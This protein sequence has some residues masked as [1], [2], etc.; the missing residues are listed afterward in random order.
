MAR[1]YIGTSGWVYGAWKGRFYPH[2]LPDAQRLSFYATK[3]A[4][5]EINYSYYHLPFLQ[6]Y[7]KWAM[8]VPPGF[9]FA[10]KA[11][12][13]ITHL[14]RL[15]NVDKAWKDFVQGAKELRQHLGPILV[16]LPPSF[17]KNHDRLKAFLE[18]TS[19]TDTSLRLAFEFRHESWFAEETYKLL[20]RYGAALCIADSISRPRLNRVTADFAYVR[21]HGRTPRE[22]PCYT[23][24]ELRQEA[25]FIGRL[26]GQGIDAYVYFNN[27]ALAHAPSN[28]ARLEELLN[29]MRRAA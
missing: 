26:V 24:E 18:T 15:K 4:A 25:K 8:L 13:A 22:A 12:R 23:D 27:D 11:N 10:I 29:E 19:G 14:A 5:T 17:R 16:Q 1:V 7:R 28:A 20:T 6:T 9:V 21:Y 3:F 2:G